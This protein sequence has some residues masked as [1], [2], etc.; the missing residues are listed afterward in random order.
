MQR[1]LMNPGPTN[2]S[3]EVR[4]AMMRGDFSHRD[5]EVRVAASAVRDG[6]LSAT[7]GKE[8]H[9]CILI[10]GSGTAAADAVVNSIRGHVLVIV[11]GRYS[12]RLLAIA[13]RYDI[14]HTT[15]EFDPIADEI[16]I[17]AVR[18]ALVRSP[19]IT[20]VLLVHHETTTG[21][22]APLTEIGALCAETGRHLVVDTV[23]GVGGHEFDLVRDNVAFAIINPNKC[24]ESVPGIGIVLARRDLIE[25][26]VGS[27]R[28][29]Y[30]D[31]YEHWRRGE[32][33]EFRYTLP[34]QVLFALEKAMDLWLREG[35]ANRIRRYR[36][37]AE[38]LRR[39]L[40]DE[41]L[42]ILEAE[43]LWRSNV[44]TNIEMSGGDEFL[45]AVDLLRHAGYTMYSN[46]GAIQEKRFFVATM[47]QITVQ[48]ID[49]F[50]VDLGEALEHARL[51]A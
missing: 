48:Q 18:S 30:L 12:E 51:R 4:K 15:I 47:G 25:D 28:S 9:S 41:A 13:S 16:D 46:L 10:G 32:S 38:R 49:R 3:R 5:T 31:L 50:V 36:R 27:S 1:L 6:L 22:L 45:R 35:V 21:Y 40:R 39:R 14:P 17:D 44:I 7:N 43:H 24:I 20:H 33:G 42:P 29:F 8:T 37:N 26:A 34:V 19:E 2:T 11:N 23:S